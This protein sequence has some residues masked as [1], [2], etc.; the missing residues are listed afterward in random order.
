M[1]ENK[2]KIKL[3]R[4]FF[5]LSI[6]FIMFSL[7]CFYAWQVIS[8]MNQKYQ[9]HSLENEVKKLKTE[10][11]QLKIEVAQLQSVA[12]VQDFALESAM[13]SV[14]SIVYLSFNASE[15]IVKK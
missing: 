10:N 14:P 7:I 5:G 9:R 12:R 11:Q 1:A 6:S 2:R 15:V 8:L 4:K 3:I 13:S